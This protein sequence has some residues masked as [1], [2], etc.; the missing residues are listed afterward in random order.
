LLYGVYFAYML[1]GHLPQLWAYDSAYAKL[2]VGDSVE[3][4]EQVMGQ[5]DDVRARFEG[6][7]V[8]TWVYRAYPPVLAH[9]KARHE[10][11]ATRWK[12]DVDRHGRVVALYRTDNPC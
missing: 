6:E 4:L 9:D 1:W 7:R 10:F 12:I 8:R 3:R 5:P 11:L 2:T